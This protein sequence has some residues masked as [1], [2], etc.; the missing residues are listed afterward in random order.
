MI[1]ISTMVVICDKPYENTKYNEYFNYF[2]FE[3]SDFQKYS[4]E[5]IVTGNHSLVTAHTGSGKTLP[6]EFAIRYF[7]SKGKKIVYTSPI[8]ALSNQKYYEF[9]N[10]YPDISFGIFTGDIKMNP[11]ADVLIMTTEI[12]MNYLYNLNSDIIEKKEDDF[13]LNINEEL[14]CVIF[15]EVHYINDENRGKNWEQTILMLPEHIQMI[16][17]SATIDSP[18][19]FAKWCER[20]SNTKQVYLSSTYKRVVPL[21]HYG[22]LITNEGVF[23]TIKNKELQEKI[24][25]K[26]NKFITLKS[27]E[28]NFDTNGYLSLKSTIDLFEKNNL[29][30]NRTHCLNKLAFELKEQEML[31]AIA[32]VFSRKNVEVYAKSIT[33]NILEFDSKIPYTIKSECDSI[34]RKLPNYREYMNL[35]EYEELVKLLE[36]GIGIHHSGMIPILRE[37][38]EYMISKKN[39]KLLFAT[40]SFAIGLDCPIRTAIFTSLT[41]FDG[42]KMRYLLPHEYSQAA[43]RAGR[44]GLDTVGHIIHCNNMFPLPSE[45]EYKDILCGKPQVLVSKFQI[46]FQVIL[47]LIKNGSN[48]KEE[49]V[50][51]VNKSMMKSEIMTDIDREKK[52]NEKLKEEL[53]KKREYVNNLRTPLEVCNRYIELTN[54]NTDGIFKKISNKL[55]KEKEREIESIKSENRF[56]LDNVKEIKLLRDIEDEFNNSLKYLEYCREYISRQIENVCNLLMEK[57]FII[58][59]ENK[60]ELTELGE[61]ASNISEINS[62]VITEILEKFNYFEEYDTQ[63]IIGIL[64]IFSDIKIKEELKSS[65]PNTKN[66]KIKEIVNEIKE[67]YLEYEKL[68][69][70]LSISSGTDYD[71]SITNDVIDILQE[72]CKLEDETQC[73]YFIAKCLDDKE[74][75]IGDFT[76]GILKISTISKEL[77]KICNKMEKTLCLSK[78]EEVDTNILKYVATT[79]SLYI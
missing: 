16:M 30:I 23:K 5:A 57:N 19:K 32:F 11:C 17:L 8:K 4:I 1:I 43:G 31:P 21:T 75:S 22:F 78:L 61:N 44:R 26:T 7:K 6:A 2:N 42:E 63:E 74:I 34:I 45:N 52:N 14:A 18:D 64:S 69:Y 55:K 40:E 49:F 54:E 28:D 60:Y 56:L 29:F 77:S 58:N 24:K 65:I 41:K 9:T 35:P 68:E 71:N 50:E 51:F 48:K 67:S 79:Q 20:E 37:I 70:D 59:D 76:K 66:K 47:N 62:L 15:D 46:S 72:W 33:T 39:I 25:G 10:K 3:L 53:E 38:V 12:L 13:E 73:K 36:K 27:K